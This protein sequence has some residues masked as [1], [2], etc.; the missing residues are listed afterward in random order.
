MIVTDQLAQFDLIRKATKISALPS[1]NLDKYEY[2]TGE[3]LGLRPNTVEQV[4]FDCT[5]LGKGFN[6]WLTKKTKILKNIEDKNEGQ[7]KTI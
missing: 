5:P 7:P 1:N 2:L 4:K 3:D 6:K